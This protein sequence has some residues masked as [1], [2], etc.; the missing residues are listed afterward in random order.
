MSVM[1]CLLLQFKVSW[2][3]VLI[4]IASPEDWFAIRPF[5]IRNRHVSL[6]V[7]NLRGLRQIDIGVI[8]F[9]AVYIASTC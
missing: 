7:S 2:C 6:V 5:V 4:I 1:A 8:I 9:I 3:S